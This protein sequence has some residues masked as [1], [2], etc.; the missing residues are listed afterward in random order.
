MAVIPEIDQFKE[1]VQSGE[2]IIKVPLF[3][4]RIDGII[5]NT[6]EAIIISYE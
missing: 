1:F 5:Y 2:D 3:V 6:G 4:V